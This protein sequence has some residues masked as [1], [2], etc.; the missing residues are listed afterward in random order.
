MWFMVSGEWLFQ[1]KCFIS[2]KI[3]SSAVISPEVKQKVQFSENKEIGI[4]PPGPICNGDF[5]TRQIDPVEDKQEDKDEEG[6]EQK[7]KV[8]RKAI[9]KGLELNKDYRGV[10]KEVWVLLNRIYGGGP[11]IAREELDIYS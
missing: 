5:L 4:L 8:E 1:W 2:N 3:S 7:E 6:A 10:N 9:K 11:V